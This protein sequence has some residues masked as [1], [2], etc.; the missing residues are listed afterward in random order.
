MLRVFDGRREPIDPDTRLLVSAID[1][2]QKKVIEDFFSSNSMLLNDLE[3]FD[4]FGDNYTVIV[5]A[6]KFVQAGFTPIHI[7]PTAQQH[8]DLMLLPKDGTFKFRNAQLPVLQE[9]SPKLFA[10]LTHG[11]SSDDAKKRYEQLMEDKPAALA[12]L[13]NIATAL[14]DIHLP[15]G[16]PL[17]YFKEMI[18]DDSIQRDRFFAFADKALVDQVNQA[19]DQGLF[20]PEVGSGFFH[21]GATS[22][23]KQVQFGEANVQITFHENDR[24]QIEGID[25]VKVEPDID[26]FRDLLAH[27]LLEVIPQAITGR[28]TDPKTVYVLRWIA[29]RHAGVPE[30]SPPYTI[31]A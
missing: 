16:N 18:W 14:A 31:E 3:F 12:A 2:N 7:S 1:G 23:F 19:R 17:D 30:F 20:E 27:A 8:L 5:S 25:C 11:V 26:Y 28:L 9:S 24:R 21:P 15:V 10:L 29:G 22:S 4:N 6:D 13:L